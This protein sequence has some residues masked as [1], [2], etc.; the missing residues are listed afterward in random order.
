MKG[1]THWE[2]KRDRLG[3]LGEWESSSSSSQTHI[4]NFW[5]QRHQ[6]W[7]HIYIQFCFACPPLLP[8]YSF[9]LCFTYTD[10]KVLSMA[11]G[12]S[13]RSMPQFSLLFFISF[14]Q[15]NELSAFCFLVQYFRVRK[16]GKGF[17]HYPMISKYKAYS[18]L[19]RILTFGQLFQG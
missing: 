1:K 10:I 14:G 13:W 16:H 5:R 12:L 3:A 19:H 2:K 11:V 7:L 17:G 4:I 9:N 18:S 15:V 8:L 6:T